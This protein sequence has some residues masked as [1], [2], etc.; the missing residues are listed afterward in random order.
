MQRVST[1]V[2]HQGEIFVVS[3]ES[4]EEI[5]NLICLY[6]TSSAMS[7]RNVDVIFHRILCCESILNLALWDDHRS[8]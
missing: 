2:G 5:I 6:L 3:H 8:D 7:Y 4:A 1:A